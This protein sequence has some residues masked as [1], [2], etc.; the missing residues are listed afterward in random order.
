[1]VKEAT[2][3]AGA[4]TL[5]AVRTVSVV[6]TQSNKAPFRVMLLPIAGATAGVPGQ[7]HAQVPPRPVVAAASGTQVIA[8]VRKVGTPRAALV[9][10]PFLT[11]LSAALP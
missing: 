11:R 1:M 5:A 3:G 7:A 10:G 2:K 6:I 8:A 9:A 4:T